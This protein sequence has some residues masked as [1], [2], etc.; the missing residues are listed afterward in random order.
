MAS[1]AE[2]V[3]AILKRKKI[4]V[5]VITND[6]K[7]EPLY[8]TWLTCLN[9]GFKGRKQ[10]QSQNEML[11]RIVISFAADK[12]FM[13]ASV[14]SWETLRALGMK[15]LVIERIAIASSGREKASKLDQ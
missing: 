3:D 7:M 2:E 10:F 15:T 1:G 14:V 5:G 6:K 9:E 11:D 12:P 13:A 8:I 4:K